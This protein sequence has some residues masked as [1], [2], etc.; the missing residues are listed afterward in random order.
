MN[1]KKLTS[2]T[3]G[4]HGY[5]AKIACAFGSFNYNRV[6]GVACFEGGPL[7]H[8]FYESWEHVKKYITECNKIPLEGLSATDFQ[9]RIDT[10]VD[11]Y[12]IS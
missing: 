8:S 12:L 11:V 7:D 4:G 10:I 3:A 5:G 1:E 9:K 2:V 6:T